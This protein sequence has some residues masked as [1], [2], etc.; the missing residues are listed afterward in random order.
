MV[1]VPVFSCVLY[2]QA[3][4]AVNTRAVFFARMVAQRVEQVCVKV[5]AD[6]VMGS[7]IM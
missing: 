4:Q 3:I 6:G 2:V 1:L 7:N 5:F